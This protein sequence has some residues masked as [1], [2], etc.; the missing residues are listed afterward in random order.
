L[1]V[2]PQSAEPV[3]PEW[4]RLDREYGDRGFWTT[5]AATEA[6][7]KYVRADLFDAE[8]QAREAAERGKDEAIAVMKRAV[9]AMTEANNLLADSEASLAEARIAELEAALRPVGEIADGYDTDGEGHPID[10]GK[11]VP[12]GLGL[13]RRARSVLSS[14]NKEPS[15]G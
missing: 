2:D 1:T 14:I 11:L 15:H 6:S 13:F 5:A 10:D 7:Q 9:D 4:V 8:R 12:V 3:A